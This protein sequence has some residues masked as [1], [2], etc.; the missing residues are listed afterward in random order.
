MNLAVI[1]GKWFSGTNTSLRGMFDL[2]SNIHHGTPHK[3]HYEMFNDATAFKEIFTRLAEKNGIHN[4]YIASHGE[5]NAIYGSNNEA[6]SKTKVK[7]IVEETSRNRGRVD[8]L[9]FGCCLFGNDKV[10]ED[11]LCAGTQL[12]WVA[13]YESSVD[14][15]ESTSLDCL[16]WHRYLSEPSGTALERV[17]KT[18]QKLEK[19][20]GGL[21]KRLGFRVYAWDRNFKTLL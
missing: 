18:V 1:E 7:N 6:I 13:G 19:D 4:I 17:Y 9:Y 3:Y 20:A 5:D 21:I 12:R 10:M 8:S 16:F 2:L 15:I 11:V 14:Y